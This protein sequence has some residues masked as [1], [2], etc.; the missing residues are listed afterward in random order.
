MTLFMHIFLMV[1]GVSNTGRSIT[2][3]GM[4][5]EEIKAV[6]VSQC[7]KDNAWQVNHLF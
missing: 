1:A 2:R 6:V 7:T 3:L 5:S 4:W